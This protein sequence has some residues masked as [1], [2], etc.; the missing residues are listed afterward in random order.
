MMSI[1]YCVDISCK[2][3]KK[4]V[5]AFSAYSSDEFSMIGGLTGEYPI[6]MS[7]TGFNEVYDQYVNLEDRYMFEYPIDLT[8]KQKE[9]FALKLLSSY[10][11]YQGEYYFIGNNCA[12]ELFRII[13][14]AINRKSAYEKQINTP[15]SIR[16]YLLKTRLSKPDNTKE[17]KPLQRL[18][19]F[20]NKKKTSHS[21][22]Y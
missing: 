12:S 11:E 13:S 5:I 21:I 1:E 17:Y 14:F 7:V 8:N 20:Y 2:K 22:T 15:N 4:M 18:E 10:W 19:E 16:D 9:R 6:E 3:S